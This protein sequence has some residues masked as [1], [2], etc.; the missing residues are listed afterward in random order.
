M[1]ARSAAK[2]SSPVG[3]RERPVVA[4]VAEPGTYTMVGVTKDTNRRV[5]GSVAA[6]FASS[7]I[8]ASPLGPLMS[9]CLSGMGWVE[10]G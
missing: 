10:T 7:A 6:E 3:C 4:S 1:E 2:P 9:T 8:F 5:M